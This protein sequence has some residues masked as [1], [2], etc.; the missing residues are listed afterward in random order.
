MVC[1]YMYQKYA[2]PII[3]LLYLLRSKAVYK[4][5]Y[6]YYRPLTKSDTWPIEQCHFR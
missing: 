4:I 6:S 1:L 3:L 5:K 2:W